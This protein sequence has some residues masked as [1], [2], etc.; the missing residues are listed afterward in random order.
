MISLNQIC[1]SY[2]IEIE[3]I[4]DLADFG[5]FPTIS[6]GG[7]MGIEPDG[8]GRLEEI[9]SLS[10]ALGINKEGIEVVLRLRERISELEAETERLQNVMKELECHMESKKLAALEQSGLLIE[11]SG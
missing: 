6:F 11:I 5:L 3:S 1:A 9:I 8:L 7:E 2:H 4:R 10:Q